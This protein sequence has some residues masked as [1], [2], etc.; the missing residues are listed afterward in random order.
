MRVK[1]YEWFYLEINGKEYRAR[2]E[3][4][5][6]TYATLRVEI[7]VQYE[8]PKYI[9]FGEKIPK[10]RWETI[11][12]NSREDIPDAHSPIN[13]SRCYDAKNS[14]YIVESIVHYQKY[15]KHTERI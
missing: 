12:W 15:C 2:Y 9:F 6:W 1:H 11:V 10:K 7:E 13:N 3:E 5:G 8:E 14:R 4:Y